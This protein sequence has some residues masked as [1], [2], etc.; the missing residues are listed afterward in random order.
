MMAPIVS[1]QHEPTWKTHPQ[2]FELVCGEL[3]RLEAKVASLQQLSERMLAETGTQLLDWTD[4]LT[5]NCAGSDLLEC[6]FMPEEE[7]GMGCFRHPQAQLP[8]VVIGYDKLMIA[9]KVESVVDFLEAHQLDSRH[10]IV[11]SIGAA[12]RKCCIYCDSAA[13]V[14]VIERH[15]SWS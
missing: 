7:W 15:G 9:I 12:V 1:M 13:E 8:A 6:G 3:R 14:W 2:A 11:G 4:R 5:V 10:Q